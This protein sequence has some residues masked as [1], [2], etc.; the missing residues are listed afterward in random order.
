[1]RYIITQENEYYVA[2][3]LIADVSSFGKSKNEALN[4]LEEALE[5]YFE[6]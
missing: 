4:N 5:L 3:S 2:Q 1:M 6:K